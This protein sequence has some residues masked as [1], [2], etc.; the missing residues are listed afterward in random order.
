M[1]NMRPMQMGIERTVPLRGP[2]GA[3]MRGIPG[4][5]FRRGHIVPKRG[6][7]ASDD[8]GRRDRRI[9]VRPPGRGDL[10]VAI[11]DARGGLEPGLICAAARPKVSGRGVF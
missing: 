10:R 5:D 9:T 8:V 3:L 4:V 6:G 1:Q 11:V 2:M 7:R